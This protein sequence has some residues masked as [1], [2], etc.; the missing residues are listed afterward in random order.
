MGIAGRFGVRIPDRLGTLSVI[1]GLFTNSGLDIDRAD[2]FTMVTEV[3]TPLRIRRRRELGPQ[4]TVPRR[5]FPTVARSQREHALV[6]FRL[7]RSFFHLPL[8]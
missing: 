5:R 2:T 1:S 8:F 6:V 7:P 4:L 3:E